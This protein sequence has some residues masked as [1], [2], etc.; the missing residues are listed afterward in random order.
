MRPQGPYIRRARQQFGLAP[1]SGEVRLSV[2]RGGPLPHPRHQFVRPGRPVSIGTLDLGLAQELG[3][4]P[5]RPPRGTA[6]R[7]PGL[8][9]FPALP[10]PATGGG[11]FLKF[12]PNPSSFRCFI[13]SGCVLIAAVKPRSMVVACS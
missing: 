4:N 1:R 5:P 6:R 12:F 10:S 8:K 7:V 2:D 11:G 9:Y 13:V 3:S